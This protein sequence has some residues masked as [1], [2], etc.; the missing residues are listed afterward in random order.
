MDSG[1]PAAATT[2]W[3]FFKDI[4]P[5]PD[6]CIS[7]YWEQTGVEYPECFFAHDY[8]FHDGKLYDVNF[9][10][11]DLD[12]FAPNVVW[13]YWPKIQKQNYT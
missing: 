1:Q 5:E 3:H 11:V 10:P 4:K 12:I 6:S 9:D 13:S 8:A 2:E 7:V